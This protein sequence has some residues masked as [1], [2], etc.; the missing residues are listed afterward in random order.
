MQQVVDLKLYITQPHV[1]NGKTIIFLEWQGTPK[2]LQLWLKHLAETAFQRLQI[3]DTDR[4]SGY[5]R[6]VLRI[7]VP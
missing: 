7:F 6:D 3:V 1:Y 5:R 4:R 2:I